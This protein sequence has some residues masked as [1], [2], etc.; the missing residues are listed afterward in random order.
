MSPH[1][2]LAFLI[3]WISLALLSPFTLG[4][5]TTEVRIESPDGRN[6]ILFQSPDIEDQSLQYTITR[7]GKTLFGPSPVGSL[8][9]TGEDLGLEAKINEVV[10]GTTDDSFILL[11]G[12]TKT[13]RDHFAYAEI[14]LTSA[15]GIPWKIISRAYNDGVAFRTIHGDQDSHQRIAIT[16]EATEFAAIGNPTVHFMP[17]LDY[18][19]S[20]EALYEQSP[21]AELPVETLFDVPLLV[22][23]PNGQ[24]A[25][26]AEAALLNYAG[27]YLQRCSDER[28]P[29]LCVK[30]S[31]L[32]DSKDLCVV[33]EPPLVSPW[34]VVL[35]G[36]HAGE[37]LESNLLMCLNEPPPAELGDF[38]WAIPGK[39]TFHWWAGEFEHD[40][41]LPPDSQQSLERHK[42]YIDF[43][44]RHGIQYHSVSGNGLSWYMQSSTDYAEPS[45]DADVRKPRPEIQLKEILSYAKQKD[46]DIRLW[47]HWKPLSNQLEEAF[48]LYEAWGVK[49]L[50]VDF[51]DRDD[52]EMIEFTQR[53][54][55]SAARHKLHI[56]IHG[57]THYSGEQRT[58][59]NLF[60]RE[61]VLN[62]EYLKWSDKCTPDHAVNVAY[63][64]SLAGPVD[65]HSGGY[66]SVSRSAFEP[67]Y[68][69]PVVLGTRCH[70]LATYVVFE[71]PMPMVADTPERYEGQPGFDFIVEVPTTWDETRFVVGEP[72]DFIV[73]ARRSGDTWYLGGITDWTSREIEV[74]LDFLG[75]N[76]FAAKLF[77][78]GSMDESKPNELT[79]LKMS[80]NSS[81]PLKISLASGGGFV[82]V[83]KPE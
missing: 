12:K 43:C 50:M 15:D 14:S 20:H 4:E 16:G 69:D 52:Q 60:N 76:Q 8:L 24:A 34:R 33:A 45:T 66:L 78:D 28:K 30:L 68:F 2:L 61:G 82:A 7:D 53:M 80:V 6:G 37:L 71:N 10:H 23:W 41:K 38:S 56:Q 74:P 70:H 63:T 51:L 22:V 64:R 36:D 55:E 13:V 73:L 54:L 29:S 44:A 39:T 48:T 3:P 72:G 62:L 5:E 1:A 58:F 11:W 83:L 81:T 67:Q 47:V 75:D 59:P 17:L 26:I 18:T 25:A 49:G 42:H 32:P 65:Y 35:L 40:D 19:S 77:V 46:V 31:P 79:E 9:A 27:M 57:S 21:F